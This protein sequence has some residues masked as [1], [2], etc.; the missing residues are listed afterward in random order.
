MEP[1]MKAAELCFFAVPQQ[2][3]MFRVLRLNS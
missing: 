3:Y 1:N 2:S